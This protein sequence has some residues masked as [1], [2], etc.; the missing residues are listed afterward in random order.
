MNKL[1]LIL[2]CL[3]LFSCGEDRGKIITG[4]VL[5]EEGITLDQNTRRPITG[6][7]IGY[8]LKEPN[9]DIKFSKSY[10]RGLLDGPSKQFRYDGTLESHYEYVGGVIH[11]PVRHYYSSG[12][13][14]TFTDY[15]KGE[16]VH[17]KI[18]NPNG[19][20]FNEVYFK[21]GKKEGV[22][23]FYS[24]DGRLDKVINWKNGKRHGTLRSNI[25]ENSYDLTEYKDGTMISYKRIINGKPQFEYF[26][27]RT[28]GL[29]DYLENVRDNEGKLLYRV[30]ILN[31]GSTGEIFG[32]GTNFQDTI[33]INTNKTW[34]IRYKNLP[35]RKTDIFEFRG[36]GL[37]YSSGKNLK[38][39]SWSFEGNNIIF[40]D[41]Y[42]TWTGIWLGDDKYEGVFDFND[43][44]GNWVMTPLK[45]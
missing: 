4:P 11:G 1:F 26:Y 41:G 18:F 42:R 32:T 7:V 3:F 43:I 21:N 16:R 35:E 37:I 24:E 6:V 28:G 15:Y 31:G 39:Y 9:R 10:Y 23:N 20:L 36:N 22:E 5:I 38:N 12:E 25:T 30:R 40:G 34:E 19:R 14:F 33:R 29:G 17:E 44:K 27:L 45:K 2:C 8:Y 13:L